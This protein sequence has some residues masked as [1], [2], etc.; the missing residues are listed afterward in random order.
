MKG[1]R[2]MDRAPSFSRKVLDVQTIFAC[3]V[4]LVIVYRTATMFWVFSGSVYIDLEA[5]GEIISDM[6]PFSVFDIDISY[7][8]LR[9]ANVQWTA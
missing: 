4:E 8:W 3:H 6:V 7:G 2:W 9:A 5:S 1:T